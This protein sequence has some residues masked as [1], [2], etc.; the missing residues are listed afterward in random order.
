MAKLCRNVWRYG[1]SARFFLPV[2]AVSQLFRAK[3]R[4]AL[5]KHDCFQR[6]TASVWSQDWVVHSQPV[7][8]GLKAL[9][10]LAPYIF[11]VAI[12]NKRLVSVSDDAVSFRYRPSGS[13]DWRLCSLKPFEFIR[14]FLQHVLPKGFVKVRY[15]GFFSPGQRVQLGQIAAWFSP[16]QS[17]V[18]TPQPEIEMA[19][20][21]TDQPA[22]ACPYC[23][24]LLQW[25][26][27]SPLKRHWQ[28]P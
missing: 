2:R 3:F 27:L 17:D 13:R 25:K 1:R 15:Y 23:G 12:S 6:I 7:G 19:Q 5:K 4:D 24:Q 8:R 9:R 16:P 14:R 22:P 11:R 28:P 26:P 10:Y 18:L 20:I 21:T